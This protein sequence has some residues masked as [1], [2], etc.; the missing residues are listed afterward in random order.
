MSCSVYA[1]LP[2]G[3]G[4]TTLQVNAN[5]VRPITLETGTMRCEGKVVHS[6]SRTATAEARLVDTRGRLYAHSTTTCM[7]FAIEASAAPRG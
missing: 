5:L 2:A 6:G 3:M 7:T 4:F 1:A